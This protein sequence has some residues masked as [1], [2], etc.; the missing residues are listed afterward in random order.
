MER[1]EKINDYLKTLNLELG[2][3]NLEN[4][5]VVFIDMCE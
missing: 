1:Y 5:F 4:N 3:F 2:T